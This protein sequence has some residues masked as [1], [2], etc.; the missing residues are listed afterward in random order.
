MADKWTIAND[1]PL[2]KAADTLVYLR[3]GNKPGGLYEFCAD[4]LL[5][6]HTEADADSMT[7][8]TLM[9]ACVFEAGYDYARRAQKQRK[10]KK[11][12]APGEISCN[13]RRPGAPRI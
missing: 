8:L 6:W 7:N 4:M 11:G 9:L 1:L 10:R 12:V 5:M 2:P 3:K 13:I